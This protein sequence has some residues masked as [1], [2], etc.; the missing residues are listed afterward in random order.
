[1]NTLPLPAIDR[2]QAARCGGSPLLPVLASTAA[3][4]LALLAAAHISSPASSAA[5]DG[6]QIAVATG[7]ASAA[8]A[9]PA[10]T[11]IVPAPVIDPRAEMF[12]GTGDG[13]AGTWVRR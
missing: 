9:P 8:G 6:S 1:M 10:T 3:A 5:H 2:A 11:A 4:V 12:V 13:S 7:P